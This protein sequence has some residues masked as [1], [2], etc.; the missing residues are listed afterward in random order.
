MAGI[1][2]PISMGWQGG[3]WLQLQAFLT[4]L[5]QLC[6]CLG[7]CC[8]AGVIVLG[9]RERENFKIPVKPNH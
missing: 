4:L 9:A 8:F 2:Y 1:I 6:P 3:G 7:C 5:A